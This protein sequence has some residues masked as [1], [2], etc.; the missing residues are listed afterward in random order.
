MFRGF[1]VITRMGLAG[2]EQIEEQGGRTER[3]HAWRVSGLTH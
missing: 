3:T 1:R 2:T